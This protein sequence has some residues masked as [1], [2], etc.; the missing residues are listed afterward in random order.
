MLFSF[1]LVFLE[2]WEMWNWNVWGIR[3]SQV[4]QFNSAKCCKSITC[5]RDGNLKPIQCSAAS[6]FYCL[7]LCAL[8][9]CFTSFTFSPH[10]PDTKRIPN[11]TTALWLSL[12]ILEILIE[13]TAIRLEKPGKPR[14]TGCQAEWLNGWLALDASNMQC[15]WTSRTWLSPFLCC[16]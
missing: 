4:C 3:F 13:W 14:E 15:S 16:Q 10:L 5:Y 9:R 2:L 12:Q 1:W 11:A 7:L 8:L 6:I